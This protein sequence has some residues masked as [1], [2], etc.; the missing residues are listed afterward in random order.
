MP[1]YIYSENDVKKMWQRSY[2]E[3]ISVAQAKCLEVIVKTKV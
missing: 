1:E 2:Y 3:Q